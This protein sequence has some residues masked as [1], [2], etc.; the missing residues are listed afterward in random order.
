ME[1]ILSILQL[2]IFV[3]ALTILTKFHNGFDGTTMF[4]NLT[5]DQ[6]DHDLSELLSMRYVL[7][8]MCCVLCYVLC[9]V[10]EQII[11]Y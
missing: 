10:C 1:S 6:N 9:V 7:C 2:F 3:Q 4:E 11:D 5:V 8:V